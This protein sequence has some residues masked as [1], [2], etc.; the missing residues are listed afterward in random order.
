MVA[1][2]AK[3]PFTSSLA[4]STTAPAFSETSS[5]PFGPKPIIDCPEG[6]GLRD[7]KFPVRFHGPAP[8]ETNELACIVPLT[9]SAPSIWT[10]V[11]NSLRLAVKR[12]SQLAPS[13]ALPM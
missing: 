13:P 10:F 5:F 8:V 4:T 9:V 2:P 12:S 11:L 3:F 6:A 1:L 7:P